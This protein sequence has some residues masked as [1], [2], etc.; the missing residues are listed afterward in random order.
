MQKNHIFIGYD[1]REK[2]PYDVCIQSLK[3]NSKNPDR[4]VIHALNHR[5]LRK[6]GYFNRPWEILQDGTYRDVTDGRP[7]SVQFSHSR[8]LT[9]QLAKDMGITDDVVMFVDCDFVFLQDVNDLFDECRK[10]KH[11]FP[12]QV[13]KHEY[14]PKEG[15][16]KMDGSKQL[17]YNKKLW[18][19]LIMFNTGAKQNDV[20]TSF[21]VNNAP[22]SWLHS[23]A[24]LRDD[25]IGSI[26]EKWN[27][28]P[29]H[30]ENRTGLLGYDAGAI[31]YTEGGP[32]F[33]NYEDCLYGDLWTRYF[34]RRH[35]GGLSR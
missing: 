7:F 17:S 29:N 25:E 10:K 35:R 27:F 34:Y 28:L 19:S 32:W 3:D 8:F 1:E 31:H 13:V 18:S 20:L 23:F 22:G 24:W 5:D 30:S 2:D 9:N 26:D 16:I 4:I 33:T 6:R 15:S 12:V 11:E 14:L 21:R